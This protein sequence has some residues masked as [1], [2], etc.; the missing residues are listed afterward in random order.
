MPTERARAEWSNRVRAEYHSASVTA[1]VLHL[2]IAAGLPRELL[3]TAHRIVSDELDHAELS[4][5]ALCAIGGADRPI[6]IDFAMLANFSHPDGA[7]AELVQ[8]VLHSF[9]FG[10][11]LAVPLFREMRTGT[12]HPVARTALDRILVDEAVHRAFG[13]QA[14][15][16][17]LEV[18]GDG[19][20]ALLQSAMPATLRHFHTAYGLAPQGTPLTPDEVAVGLLSHDTYRSVFQSTWQDD[21]CER[22]HRRAVATPSMHW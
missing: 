18:D 2:A 10:E 20:R 9:C 7:L 6:G 16:A 5:D 1:R 19:V 21:I 15:D 11:T 17:L 12:T 14:L 8:H 3:D 22:F 4:H 13:W